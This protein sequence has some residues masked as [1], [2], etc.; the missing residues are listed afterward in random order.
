MPCIKCRRKLEEGQV[1]CS[2]CL[3]GMEA[4]PVKPGTPIQL[5]PRLPELPQ[6]NRRKKQ[7]ERKPE[8]EIRRLRSSIRWLTLALVIVLLAF[9]LM[10]TFVLLLLREQGVTPPL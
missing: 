2:S 7:R 9:V 8:V 10:S 1:F 6:K 3:E 5:P 4:Y